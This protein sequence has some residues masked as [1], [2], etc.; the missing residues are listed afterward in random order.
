MT[1]FGRFPPPPIKKIERPFSILADTAPNPDKSLLSILTTMPGTPR[2]FG[3]GYQYSDKPIKVKSYAN[4][5]PRDD[6]KP[7]YYYNAGDIVYTDTIGYKN[8]TEPYTIRRYWIVK[9][10]KHY[11]QSMSDI[12]YTWFAGGVVNPN[13]TRIKRFGARFF[14]PC[15]M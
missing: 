9:P 5:K 11:N 4:A 10:S 12:M 8:G 6:T 14:Q 2:G 7:F 1:N 3:E 13:D 15:S